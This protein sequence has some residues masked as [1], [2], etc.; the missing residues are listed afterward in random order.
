MTKQIGLTLLGKISGVS[1]IL[2]CVS[3]E[4]ISLLILKHFIFTF[5]VI[6]TRQLEQ[7]KNKI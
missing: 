1:V 4:T 7:Q 5:H 3:C 2:S 6:K